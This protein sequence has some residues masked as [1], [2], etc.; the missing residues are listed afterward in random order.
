MFKTSV[1]RLFWISHGRCQPR[2]RRAESFATQSR[3]QICFGS[4]YEGSVLKRLQS[5]MPRQLRRALSRQCYGPRAGRRPAS[6]WQ[7]PQLAKILG[8][9]GFKTFSFHRGNL[10]AGYPEPT[11]L[12]VKT[13]LCLPPFCYEKQREFDCDLL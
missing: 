12:L 9:P 7:W 4:C 10:G 5:R 2:Q 8:Y 3:T 1:R 11:R 6:M 13:S